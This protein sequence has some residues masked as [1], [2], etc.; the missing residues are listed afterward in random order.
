MSV[1]T[2]YMNAYTFYRKLEFLN[3]DLEEMDHDRDCLNERQLEAL[4]KVKELFKDLKAHT[5]IL[6]GATSI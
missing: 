4:D 5:L 2:E 1:T 6:I 3:E